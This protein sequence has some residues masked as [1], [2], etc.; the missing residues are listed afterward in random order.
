MDFNIQ[1]PKKDTNGLAFSYVQRYF[2]LECRCITKDNNPVIINQNIHGLDYVLL[3]T[4]TPGKAVLGIQATWMEDCLENLLPSD[5][6]L[7][8][9]AQKEELR[10]LEVQSHSEGCY[11][12]CVFRQL[13]NC[14]V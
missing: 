12:I 1:L 14:A 2:S 11:K 3:G 4:W 5:Y 10:Q 9:R 8:A 7:L 6:I 13:L